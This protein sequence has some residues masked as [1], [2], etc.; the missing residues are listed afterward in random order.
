MYADSYVDLVILDLQNIDNIHEVGRMKDIIPYTV[1]ATG[2]EYPMAYV[3]K[4]KGVVTGMES[5]NNP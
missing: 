4:R 5:E 2:N 3:D 1:P